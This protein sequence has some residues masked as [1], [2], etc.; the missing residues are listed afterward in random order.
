MEMT[1]DCLDLGLTHQLCPN[2]QT[3]GTLTEGLFY[4]RFQRLKIQTLSE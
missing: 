1:K 4:H 3:W 2:A